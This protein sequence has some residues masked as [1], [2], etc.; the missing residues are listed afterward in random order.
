VPP[1]I[2]HLDWHPIIQN[3]IATC[4]DH[5]SPAVLAPDET[6]IYDDLTWEWACPR[7]GARNTKRL[8]GADA[9][10]ALIGLRG[11]QWRRRPD[12]LL[13]VA[14]AVGVLLDPSVEQD[15]RAA[16]QRIRRAARRTR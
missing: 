6:T 4:A 13:A 7:C 1:A 11:I 12:P 9:D 10:L 5:P 14:D 8:T 15:V 2:R 16:L 3:I